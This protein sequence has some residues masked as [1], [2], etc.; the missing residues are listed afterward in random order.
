[1]TQTTTLSPLHRRTAG[2]AVVLATLFGLLA[3]VH[4]WAGAGQ[5]AMARPI[6]TGRETRETAKASPSSGLDARSALVAAST[7][8]SRIQGGQVMTVLP[9]GSMRPMFDQKAFLVLEPAPFEQLRVGDVVTFIHPK[10]GAPVV[11]RI[12][13]KHGASFWTKGDHN[14]RPDSEYVTASNYRMRVVA[15]IY[16]REDSDVLRRT[17]SN[18]VLNASAA[19]AMVR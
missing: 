14:K 17:A 7:I 15:V 8:A 18:A 9:T 3:H 13:E 10:V 1:M 11:H 6:E 19:L 12:F 4:V 16:A 2:R 5:F